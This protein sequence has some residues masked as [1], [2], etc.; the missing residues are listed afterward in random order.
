[1]GWEKRTKCIMNTRQKMQNRSSILHQETE[2]FRVGSLGG[3]VYYFLISSKVVFLNFME[4][5]Y[6]AGPLSLF[7]FAVNAV[8]YL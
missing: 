4:M 8:V 6:Q 2:E 1:M 5:Q 3:G 7:Q